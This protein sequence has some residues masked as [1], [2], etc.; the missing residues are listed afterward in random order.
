[1][2]VLELLDSTQTQQMIHGHTHRP[3][4]HSLTNG[5]RRIVVGDWYE[6][7]SMLCV[8][9]DNIELIELPFGK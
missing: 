2:A 1:D 8:S 6:Q 4:I 9:Q 7:G 5:K 3:A